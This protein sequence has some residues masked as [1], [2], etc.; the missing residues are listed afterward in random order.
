MFSTK[1]DEDIQARLADIEDF[2]DNTDYN[3][4]QVIPVLEYMNTM[5][6]ETVAKHIDIT[7]AR[8]CDCGAGFGW[9]AFA[10]LLRGG[11]EAVIVE[12]HKK[13]LAAAQEFA[14]IIGVFD[15]CEFRS[16]FLQDIDLPDKSIDI[17]ASVETLEHVGKKN[18]GP[19]LTNMERL[20]KS[21]IVLTTPNQLSPIVSHD[22]TI[23]LAH[24]L[25]KEWRQH[26]VK[27]FGNNRRRFNHFAGP[28]HLQRLKPHFRPATR[29]LT[30]ETWEDWR[31]HYPTYSPYGGGQWK[32][33]PPALF[34]LY[35]RII[36]SLLGR[37]SYWISPNLGSVWVRKD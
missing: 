34:G 37:N 33:T 27:L 2:Q 21:V 1:I 5:Y 32:R 24:W 8:L 28:W 9:L 4:L 23:P 16:D 31:A 19:A 18:I 12:P 3:D 17:F 36:S 25:P 26:Y 35:L 10:F 6:L 29:A 20:T 14:Q 22:G 7:K 30:F 15:R 11:K 13:K